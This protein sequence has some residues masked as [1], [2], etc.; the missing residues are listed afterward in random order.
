MRA[1]AR[2]L[3]A[4]RRAFQ[5]S[6]A[7]TQL[8]RVAH[9]SWGMECSTSMVRRLYEISWRVTGMPTSTQQHSHVLRYFGPLMRIRM[10]LSLH[11]YSITTEKLQTLSTYQCKPYAPR[12]HVLEKE[13]SSFLYGYKESK[14]HTQSLGELL[15][16]QANVQNNKPAHQVGGKSQRPRMQPIDDNLDDKSKH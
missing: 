1:R 12:F 16:M 4:D 10:P 13:W 3:A 5:I 11:T 6:S 8:G 15:W 7:N 9:Q 2:G 14:S